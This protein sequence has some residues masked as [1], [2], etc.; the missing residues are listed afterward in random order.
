MILRASVV[1]AVL[2]GGALSAASAAEPGAPTAQHRPVARPVDSVRCTNDGALCISRASYARD[3]CGAI[4]AAA[5]EAGLDPHFFAR[6]L[7]Q[8]SRFDPSAVSSAGALGIAQFIPAT[9]ARRG[10]RDPFNPA[11]ALVASADYLAELER[12]YGNLGLAAAAYNAGEARVDAFLARGRRLPAETRDYVRRIT[13]HE[14]EV[15]HEAPPEDPN[16]KL[17]GDTPLQEACQAMAAGR[18]PDAFPDALRPSP[19]LSP[20]GVI[21]ASHRSRDIAA[22][23]VSRLPRA[24]LGTHRI[25]YGRVRMPGHGRRQMTAQIGRQTRGEAD[26]LCR[27]LKRAGVGCLVLRN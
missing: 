6:L 3:A 22:V 26:A 1:A 18:A 12:D 10:L 27:E 25:D 24:M 7:W 5:K 4:E 15:W 23:Q 17:R 16:L 2:T 20:W 21:L 13:G 8:E 11:A 14:A 9:A 19:R